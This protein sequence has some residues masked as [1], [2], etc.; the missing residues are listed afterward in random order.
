MSNFTPSKPIAHRARAG[1]AAAKPVSDLIAKLLDPVIERRAGMT[2]DLVCAWPEIVG[3]RHAK[4]SRPEKL[5]WPRRA[6]DDDPFEPAVLVLACEQIHAVYLQHDTD[7]LVRRINAYFG[8][9]AIS[10]IKL[11]QK[12]L[13]KTT[14]RPSPEAPSL[15]GEQAARLHTMLDE[16]EDEKLREALQRMGRGVFSSS[17]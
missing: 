15:D 10:R 6:H 13:P 17:S 2:M 3:E 9:A 8:F 11:V 4:H 12:P 16:I 7:T 5:N 14:Q 1:K